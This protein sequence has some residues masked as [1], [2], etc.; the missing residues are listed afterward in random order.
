MGSQP[1]KEEVFSQKKESGFS[2][3]R[4]AKEMG[5]IVSVNEQSNDLVSVGKTAGL[6]RAE[7]IH[8]GAKRGETIT[9][10]DLSFY[11][12]EGA[13]QRGSISRQNSLDGASLG[14]FELSVPKNQ[15]KSVLK[16]RSREIM[17][18]LE[19]RA[20]EL[21]DV[22]EIFGEKEQLKWDEKKDG[23]WMQA[24]WEAALELRGGKKYKQLSAKQREAWG[25]LG[26]SHQEGV[27]IYQLVMEYYG[28]DSK[29]MFAEDGWLKTTY[30][31]KLTE[32]IKDLNER[33]KPPAL[34][35][36][37][38]RRYEEWADYQQ[39]L[40]GK[41]EKTSIEDWQKDR[42]DRYVVAIKTE[43]GETMPF[44]DWKR[45]DD[46]K[47]EGQEDLLKTQDKINDSAKISLAEVMGHIER[48]RVGEVAHAYLS[49]EMERFLEPAF[50]GENQMPA[51][52]ALAGESGR[53]GVVFTDFFNS[54][55]HD[56]LVTG[57]RASGNFFFW[58]AVGRLERMIK[59]TQTGFGENRVSKEAWAALE[60]IS[61]PV[62]QFILLSDRVL[63]RAFGKA[64]ML[65]E[66]I[67]LRDWRTG[68][69]GMMNRFD[70]HGVSRPAEKS[71]EMGP[72]APNKK[73]R[74]SARRKM[75][76]LGYPRWIA[77]LAMAHAWMSG[78]GVDLSR[79]LSKVRAGEELVFNIVGTLVEPFFEYDGKKLDAIVDSTGEKGWG[80][81]YAFRI[82]RWLTPG[83]TPFITLT[84]DAWKLMSMSPWARD[85]W[86]SSFYLRMPAYGWVSRQDKERLKLAMEKM[87]FS[88]PYKNIWQRYLGEIEHRDQKR[89]GTYFHI[90]DNVK[91]MDAG[92]EK[93][94]FW[95]Y[96]FDFENQEHV[97]RL[98]EL[99]VKGSMADKVKEKLKILGVNQA[100]INGLTVNAMK[101]L[102]GEMNTSTIRERVNDLQSQ[103]FDA[104][105]VEISST[106]ISL[107]NGRQTRYSDWQKNLDIT[108][109]RAWVDPTTF[110][111]SN[112]QHDIVT[113]LEL[114][115]RD[116]DTW[117]LK[118]DTTKVEILSRLADSGERMAGSLARFFFSTS[119][120]YDDYAGWDRFAEAF[121][122]VN[123][124]LSLEKIE[125]LSHKLYNE[126]PTRT[127]GLSHIK[128]FLETLMFRTWYFKQIAII[129]TEM[130]PG[131]GPGHTEVGTATDWMFNKKLRQQLADILEQ[132]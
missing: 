108:D 61:P 125:E 40:T 50:G 36:P 94:G 22:L 78:E 104:N 37:W 110:L 68:R 10:D 89:W 8:S 60:G 95:R 77:D 106:Q 92:G 128:Q 6:L 112:F 118:A 119:F 82:L 129:N 64:L 21:A 44:K 72:L 29:T 114:I 131:L 101:I 79:C 39:K 13:Q 83:V 57:L 67:G 24:V 99:M 71:E 70:A 74:E 124:P 103:W 96:P 28:L 42:Y 15:E 73:A 18:S 127:G 55:T 41:Q 93:M 33:Q 98:A 117:G 113:K 31:E 16:N 86:F 7:K 58:E 100:T 62:V 43:G 59:L 115:L 109:Q 84:Q 80:R 126:Y 27:I 35:Q 56:V 45:L 90:V 32:T 5:F 63:G 91:L 25:S 20:D 66:I 123:G 12:E 46:L 48:K 14:S 47:M 3:V 107:A 38:C 54:R 65:P 9:R 26:A 111:S 23:L 121:P 51:S 85:L 122:E 52:Y 1:Q 69:P 34:Y 102:I 88:G 49:S 120:L 11:V 2:L 30:G 97:H 132:T 75:A 53:Q 87:E 105:D 4:M 76:D 17:Q 81:E 116:V 19:I 130:V